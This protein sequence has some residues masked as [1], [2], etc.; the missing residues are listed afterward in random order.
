M[1]QVLQ[2]CKIL[3]EGFDFVIDLSVCAEAK[4]N[5]INE[6]SEIH[7]TNAVDVTLNLCKYLFQI[8]YNS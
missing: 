4:N 7:K 5:D 3:K 8:F 6:S 1:N 2:N